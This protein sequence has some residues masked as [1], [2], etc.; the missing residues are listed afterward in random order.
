MFFWINYYLHTYKKISFY[1]IISIE[2]YMF[3]AWFVL[4]FIARDY[5][6]GLAKVFPVL[7]PLFELK[8]MNL[9]LK[10]ILYFFPHMYTYSTFN[11]LWWA[12]SI[13]CVYLLFDKNKDASIK[14]IVF[15]VIAI[16]FSILIASIFTQY[17]EYYKIATITGR[18]LMHGHCI[19]FPL[20]VFTFAKE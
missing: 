2:T 13:M 15:Y 17:G 11:V 6:V 18:F 9:E 20:F 5:L 7:L 1:K 10:R 8:L 19:V 16:L 3:I 14:V 4:Y 12:A